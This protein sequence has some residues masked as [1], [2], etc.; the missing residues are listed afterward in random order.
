MAID[1]YLNCCHSFALKTKFEHEEHTT[2]KYY[3]EK[4]SSPKH[5]TKNKK[6]K[7]SNIEN[8]EREMFLH[9]ILHKQLDKPL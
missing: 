5:F 2:E 9:V 4:N 3:I 6:K 8:R 7:K 1:G